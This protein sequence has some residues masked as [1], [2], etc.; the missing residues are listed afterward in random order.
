MV[1]RV[2]VKVGRVASATLLAAVCLGFAVIGIGP[3]TGAYRPLTVLSSSMAPTYPGGSLLFIRHTPVEDLRVGD[4]ITYET[5]TDGRVVTHRI[6]AVVE[7][8]PEP[9][10]ITKGDA[11]DEPDPWAVRIEVPK[12]WRTI[13]G[14]PHLGRLVLALR[15]PRLR[16]TGLP[17]AAG[18]VVLI[19]LV[20]IWW[21]RGRRRPPV[22]LPVAHV[23]PT[24]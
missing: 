14:V 21:P 17:I 7:P 4:V 16:T 15:S 5:P 11:L 18:A 19:G 22:C 8:G 13:G 6:H 3:Q 1:G 23:A 10:I 20:E 2:I 12:V 9:L 24:A